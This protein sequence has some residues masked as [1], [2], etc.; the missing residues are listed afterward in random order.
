VY[1]ADRAV[2]R[3]A[4]LEPIVPTGAYYTT[5]DVSAVNA[6][7]DTAAAHALVRNR[8]VAAVRGS[9]FCSRPDLGQAKLRFSFN[10]KLDTLTEAGRRLSSIRTSMLTPVVTLDVDKRLF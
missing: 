7:D 10:K 5:S 3:D 9:S 6:S 1:A 8:R 4:G 2:L